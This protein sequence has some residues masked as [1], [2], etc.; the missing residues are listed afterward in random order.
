[1]VAA[2]E[3]W[4]DAAD[5]ASGAVT[6]LR[7][8]LKATQIARIDPEEF[9]DFQATRPEVSLV[10]GH[11]PQDLLAGQRLLRRPR[12]GGRAATSCCSPGSSPT[13]GGGPSAPR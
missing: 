6:W 10:D 12:G 11:D 8:R 4:N 13:S 3:G 7:R 2:F 5:A 9:Y 1:M